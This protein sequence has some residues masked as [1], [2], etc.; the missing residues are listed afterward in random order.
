M[1]EEL[2]VSRWCKSSVREG[3]MALINSLTLNLVF[4]PEEQGN[5]LLSAVHSTPS[6]TLLKS[7]FGDVIDQLIAEQLLVSTATQD[8]DLLAQ[9]RLSLV[10]NVRMNLCYLLLTDGCN[11]QC[12]YC[13]EDTPKALS[14]KASKMSDEVISH[15]LET[16]ARLTTRYGDSKSAKRVIHLYGGEPL[17]NSPGVQKAVTRTE[18]LKSSGSLPE[19]TKMVIVTNGALLTRDMAQFLADHQVTIG[20]S[21]DG[22]RHLNDLH[23]IAKRGKGGT[24]EK[25]ERAYKLGRECGAM[26]GL[27][28]T[29]T[30]EVVENFDEVLTYFV[31]ELGIRDG[32]SFNILHYSPQMSTGEDYYQAAAIC[33][34]KAFEVFRE[35]GIYE[36]RMMR[37]A[38]AFVKREPIFIDCGV[39]GSQI[40]IAPDGRIGACQ[41][42]V[43]PRT[44]FRGSVLDPTYDPVQD[45]LFENWKKRSPIF[46]EGCLDCKSLGICG[47]GCPASAE[48]KTGD[49]WNIDRRICPHSNLSLE[50][51]IWQT[52]STSIAA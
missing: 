30:P 42:F 7:V 39:N 44:Y 40:V 17:L 32:L 19:T 46:M 13:F 52:Y 45:G 2:C 37:K 51:L 23:R 10:E 24:F 43:K 47:G 22:P 27:S 34:I 8:D 29:L 41:D 25:A 28:A 18:E 31:E 9:S 12:R 21:L 50:W 48:L 4:L 5:C 15:G 33:L 11:F 3:V 35:R 14:F 26:V 6:R 16:F 20:I 49:R 38:R 1:S 36:E